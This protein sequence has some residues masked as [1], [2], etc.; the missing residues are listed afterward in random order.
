M[1][2]LDERLISALIRI[3]I[4]IRRKVTRHQAFTE[5]ILP[6]DQRW[7][8]PTSDH[9]HRRILQIYLQDKAY[10]NVINDFSDTPDR[11]FSYLPRN[12]SPKQGSTT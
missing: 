1:L 5:I 9:E 2:L 10:P 12:P 6:P 4:L 8:F 11:Q 3:M 7:E